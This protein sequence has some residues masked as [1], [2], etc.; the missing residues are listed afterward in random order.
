MRRVY[1]PDD[2]VVIGQ[3]RAFLE[4]SHVR[5]MVRNELL[6]GAA[7]E[8]PPTECLPE[9]WVLDDDQL[10]RARALVE[11][12]LRPPHDAEAVQWRCP[13]CGEVLEGQFTQCWSCGTERPPPG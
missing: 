3:L 13:R 6:M 4:S 7:G 10:E 9:L 11:A 8:L 1:G 5:C 12:F 2:F